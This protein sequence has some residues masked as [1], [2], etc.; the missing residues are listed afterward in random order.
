VPKKLTQ[1]ERCS[2]QRLAVLLSTSCIECSGSSGKKTIFV[3]AAQ[4]Q[5]DEPESR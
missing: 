2:Q 1:C 3:R 5:N 4:S